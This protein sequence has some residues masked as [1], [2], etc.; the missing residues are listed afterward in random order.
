MVEVSKTRRDLKIT[1]VLVVLQLE[2]DFGY[3]FLQ[4][5]PLLEVLETQPTS[6]SGLGNLTN[7]V[8]TFALWPFSPGF[9]WSP[10]LLSKGVPSCDIK[11]WTLLNCFSSNLHFIKLWSTFSKY[12]D[13]SQFQTSLKLLHNIF[14]ILFSAV[15]C[16]WNILSWLPYWIVG[17]KWG[18]WVG[19]KRRSWISGGSNWSMGGSRSTNCAECEEGPAWGEGGDGTVFMCFSKYSLKR[20]W[21]CNIA[22]CCE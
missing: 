13:I 8:Q 10:S 18:W 19:L 6:I 17:V 21:W 1:T 4:N 11:S 9:G 22:R 15:G 20:E 12:T 5:F 14:T 3:T 16:L 2:V 7:Q